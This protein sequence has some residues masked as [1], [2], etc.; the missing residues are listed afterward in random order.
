MIHQD[1][2][3]KLYQ[4]W[5]PTKRL[6]EGFDDMLDY[7][8]PNEEG[9]ILDIGC[10]IS[11]YILNQISK[12]RKFFALDQDQSQLNHLK[13][14]IESIDTTYLDK[15]EFINDNFPSVK[16]NGYKFDGIIISNILHFLEFNDCECFINSLSSY[17]RKG[18]IILI[19]VHSWKHRYNN[20][21]NV[22]RYDQIN[23]Y[24]R[25]EDFRKLFKKKDYNQLFFQERIGFVN[26][27]Q[28]L[29]MKEFIKKS[30]EENYENVSE[31][32]IEQIQKKYIR[33]NE[34]LSQYTFVY[35]KK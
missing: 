33:D 35:E 29:F 15:V 12:N 19:V 23:H 7:Y 28:I 9:L 3:L 11:P 16:L 2:Y 31:E 10:G 26:S 20:P 4:K 34:M 24:F 25:K 27:Y 14:R 13:K 1:V 17:T 6:L 8:L 30:L 5:F 21:N 18:T 32:K 22:H